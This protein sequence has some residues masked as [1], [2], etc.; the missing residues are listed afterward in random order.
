MS[1][2]SFLNFSEEPGNDYNIH[3]QKIMEM[4]AINFAKEFSTLYKAEKNTRLELKSLNEELSAQNEQLMDIVFLTSGRFLENIEKNESSFS[5]IR[6][7]L[8]SSDSELSEEL[9]VIDESI[10]KLQQSVREMGKLYRI[11]S[12]R[13]LF[14][15]TSLDQLMRDVLREVGVSLDLD[16]EAIHFEPLP[17]LET[18]DVQLRI[19]FHQLILLGLGSQHH[20]EPLALSVKAQQNV[21]GLWRIS[22][23]FKGESFL[24]CDAD[25]V[26]ENSLETQNRSLA[27]C[28]RVCQRLGGFIYGDIDSENVF[29]CHIVLP[30]KNIPHA[31]F[32]KNRSG[33]F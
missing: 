10:T 16:G 20:D 18:D 33:E 26:G 1:D 6:K 29:S 12:V 25:S 19:L 11:H 17:T 7:H 22:L 32:L 13:S 3:D 27:L 15:P 4:Q 9:T 23:Q 28:H 24:R 31:S 8:D 21:G 14:R 2:F 5:P 30:G